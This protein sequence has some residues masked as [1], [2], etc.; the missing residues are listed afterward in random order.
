[1]QGAGVGLDVDVH[2]LA[3]HGAAAQQHL[4]V[5]HVGALDDLLVD[6]DQELGVLAVVPLLDLGADFQPD[7]LS[8]HVLGDGDAA[9]EPIVAAGDAVEVR[10]LALELAFKLVGAGIGGV[11]VHMLAVKGRPVRLGGVGLLGAEELAGLILPVGQR[12]AVPE[13]EHL[14]L[15]ADNLDAL[16]DKVHKHYLTI[17]SG[18]RRVCS[19]G[20]FPDALQSAY[21]TSQT[22]PCE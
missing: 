5:V 2:G 11:P 17:S 21:H 10:V 3:A 4:A 13:P 14:E 12:A 22:L 8:V 18:K 16:I 7:G 20:R 6:E 1:M 15:V 9:A 19:Q